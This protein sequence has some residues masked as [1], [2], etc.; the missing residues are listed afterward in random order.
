MAMEST[1]LY[2][3]LL[4]FASGHISMSEESYKVVALES[5][6]IALKKLSEAISRPSDDITRHET[7]VAACLTLVI[8][9]VGTS[10]FAGW[11]AHLVGAKQIIVSAKARSSNDQTLHGPQVFKQSTE[12]RWILRNF[13]YHDIIGSI[14]MQRGPLLDASYLDGITDTVDSYVGVATGLLSH[15][16][17]IT[18][19][20]DKTKIDDGMIDQEKQRR[21]AVFHST[22]ATLE[23]SLQAWTCPPNCQEH[24]DSLAYA[25][26]AAA[27]IL[28]YRLA[29]KRLQED[30]SEGSASALWVREILRSKIRTQVYEIIN[31]ADAI[32]SGVMAE[33]ALLFPLF[34]AG[35]EATEQGQMDFVATRLEATLQKR[36]FQ[37]I[38]KALQVLRDLWSLRQAQNCD[39]VDWTTVL[40]ASGGSLLLT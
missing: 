10:D 30:D 2:E 34:I 24:H 33:S 14:T 29:R 21:R 20:D 12:G 23:K 32:P 19:L 38:A 31:Q 13:A 40:E 28:V 37:N 7:N 26:R 9:D 25:F 27:L 35:G 3:S 1:A 4:A 36:K 15:V 11:Y 8:G 6:S 17:Q 22:C 16:A 18:C 5:R 39:T